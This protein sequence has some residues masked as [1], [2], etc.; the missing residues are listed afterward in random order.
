MFGAE[1]FSNNPPEGAGSHSQNQGD[2]ARSR[3]FLEVS[4]H[5][6]IITSIQPLFSTRL[7]VQE[8]VHSGLDQ[9]HQE[10]LSYRP[11]DGHNPVTHRA[12][13]HEDSV[14]V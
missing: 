9:D 2:S 7:Y 4:E 10:Y 3:S 13:G 12:T 1:S 11:Q 5:R 14:S 6:V 8:S